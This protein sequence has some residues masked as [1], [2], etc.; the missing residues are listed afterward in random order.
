MSIMMESAG[1]RILLDC[2]PQTVYNLHRLGH[3]VADIDSILITHLHG[4]HA[5][6]LPF[7][8]LDLLFRGRGTKAIRMV[9]PSELD[10]FI[11]SSYRLFYGATDPTGLY[12]VVS[13][14]GVLPFTV[15]SIP[16]RH[17]IPAVCYRLELEGKTFVY[18]GDTSTSDNLVDFARGADYLIHEAAELDEERARLYGHSTPLQAAKTAAEAE[19]RKLFVVHHPVLPSKLVAEV[20][21]VF[22]NTIFPMDLDVM[23]I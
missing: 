18:T 10:E 22:S 9:G 17:T 23:E 7:V 4:D 15:T 5:G 19:V 21:T 8:L 20:L 12:E 3:K 16:A 13:E 11:R 6:G 2:G 1:C 14:D